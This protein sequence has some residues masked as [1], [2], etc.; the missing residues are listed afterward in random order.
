MTLTE[1]Y[2]VQP[3]SMFGEG[4]IPDAD[5]KK[6]G[7]PI[8]ICVI[9]KSYAPGAAALR[10]NTGHSAWQYLACSNMA[11]VDVIITFLKLS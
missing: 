4:I 6:Y 10:W 11:E 3:F 9:Q 5:I 8:A 1:S 2:Y 7:S